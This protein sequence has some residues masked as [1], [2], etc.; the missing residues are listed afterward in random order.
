MNK[1]KE[2]KRKRMNKI[3]NFKFFLLDGGTNRIDLALEICKGM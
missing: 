1:K 3:K 2:S